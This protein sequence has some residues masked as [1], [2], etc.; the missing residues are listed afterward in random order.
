MAMNLFTL[1][2]DY[3]EKNKL[4]ASARELLYEVFAD[5]QE[6]VDDKLDGLQS[7]F[8]E[9]NLQS[10][11]SQSIVY[12][13]ATLE[14]LIDGFIAFLVKFD[15]SLMASE[16]FNK[17]KTPM[18]EI[19]GLKND[20]KADYLSDLIISKLECNKKLGVLRF[21]CLLAPFGLSGKVTKEHQKNILAIHQLWNCILHNSS[22]ADARL[23]NACPWLDYAIG[24]K[25]YISRDTMG[26]TEKSVM[27]Y[28]SQI[29]LNINKK[30]GVPIELVKEIKKTID[31][32]F[33]D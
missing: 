33:A 4:A 7:A 25:I 19:Y 29:F 13:W 30:L 31:D 8:E 1:D 3:Q 20:R 24:D 6:Y 23:V 22:V 15:P 17:I 27:A 11:Y 9:A 10:L 18:A 2:F 14:S 5:D 16:K 12:F 32:L 26:D 21:E 28:H